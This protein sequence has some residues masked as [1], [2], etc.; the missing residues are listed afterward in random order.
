MEQD[1]KQDAASVFGSNL[2]PTTKDDGNAKQ[3]GALAE[4]QVSEMGLNYM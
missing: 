4:Q 3:A 2:S 1:G